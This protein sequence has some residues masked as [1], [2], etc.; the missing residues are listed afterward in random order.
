MFK[1][2][3]IV[4]FGPFAQLIVKELNKRVD[5]L[6]I[7]N[8]SPIT[9]DLPANAKQVE[10]SILAKAELII[11]AVPFSAF[12]PILSELKDHLNPQ[13]IVIDVCSV[14]TFPIETMLK[15]LPKTIS[16]VGTHPLFGPE[17]ITNLDHPEVV[18]CRGRGQ[19]AEQKVVQL[20]EDLGCKVRFLSPESHDK[21]MAVVH[22][23]TFYIAQA[24]LDLNLGKTE[25]STVF[26]GH[27]QKLAE[28][29]SHHS[30]DLTMT[31]EKYNPY[32]GD[33]RSKLLNI[34]SELDRKYR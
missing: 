31:V 11:I 22:G 15:I 7:Y 10:L 1:N 24:I 13:A 14:K 16:V 25:S 34:L 8:R 30:N 33:M 26:F 5:N 18:V 6:L 23:L 19:E 28:I 21:E 3:G 29:Q 2:I 20:I 32:S 9:I 27:L 17:T 4:G 12:E